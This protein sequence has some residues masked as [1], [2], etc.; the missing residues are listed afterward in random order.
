M[1]LT[2]CVFG[3]L[4][5][6]FLERVA[7]TNR[8]K[9]SGV[10]AGPAGP[11]HPGGAPVALGLPKDDMEGGADLPTPPW[12]QPPFGYKHGGGAAFAAANLAGANNRAAAA[13]RALL[14]GSSS[15][16][17]EA[18]ERK[19][20]GQWQ[21]SA[22]M[23]AMAEMQQRASEQN[24]LNSLNSGSASN[25][26]AAARGGNINALAQLTQNASGM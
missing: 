20:L 3:R 5:R 4:E 12:L 25:F 17:K 26:L 15:S 10:G 13:G 14:G 7:Q 1:R 11:S 18:L 21:G 19:A 23:L 22:N 8:V 2:L 6:R 24:L 16:I 9:S